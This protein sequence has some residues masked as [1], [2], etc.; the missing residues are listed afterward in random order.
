MK[1]S[2]HRKNEKTRHG[3]KSYTYT[4]TRTHTQR[5][6]Y[7]ENDPTIIFSFFVTI[8]WHLWTAS[9][10][11]HIEEHSHTQEQFTRLK[12]KF[13]KDE[14]TVQRLIGMSKVCSHT[15]SLS[16][17]VKTRSAEFWSH[18]YEWSRQ[19]G[20]GVSIE[21]RVSEWLL[22]EDLWCTILEAVDRHILGCHRW[23]RK[24]DE[25]H[26]DQLRR[27]KEI[28]LDRWTSTKHEEVLLDDGLV[29][30]R[31]TSTEIDWNASMNSGEQTNVVTLHW[32]LID[33]WSEFEERRQPHGRGEHTDSLTLG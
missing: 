5:V 12:Y 11:E 23:R 18:R 8:G 33:D 25:N 13:S 17:I 27:S 24:F 10:K 4:H 9:D 3:I 22:A 19:H 15:L 30:N 1:T 31:S 14:N 16:L 28:I 6:L 26:E 20:K 32:S 2:K 21:S 7:T 29:W